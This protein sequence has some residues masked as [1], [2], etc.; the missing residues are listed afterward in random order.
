AAHTLE[1][2]QAGS[3]EL[4][5]GDGFHG[6][7]GTIVSDHGQTWPNDQTPCSSSDTFVAIRSR[8]AGSP[9]GAAATAT[10]ASRTSLTGERPAD[11]WPHVATTSNHKP[12]A[13]SLAVP[14]AGEPC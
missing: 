13:A 10:G 4:R 14:L 11:R 9:P 8:C 12:Y 3:L 5:D 2:R 6:G 1:R 7:G